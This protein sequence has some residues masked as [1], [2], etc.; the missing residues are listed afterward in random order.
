VQASQAAP[1]VGN[2]FVSVCCYQ[3]RYAVTL[4]IHLD[5]NM[6]MDARKQKNFTPYSTFLAGETTYLQLLEL[7]HGHVD[8]ECSR[9]IKPLIRIYSWYVF[10][11]SNSSS[12]MG[13]SGGGGSC[14]SILREG[15]SVGQGSRAR[16]PNQ[17]FMALLSNFR[18][19]SAAATASYV[20]GSSTHQESSKVYVDLRF[21][22]RL[23]ISMGCLWQVYRVLA[24]LTYKIAC[25]SD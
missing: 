7:I 25:L 15:K 19:S 16:A 1:S 9:L 21:L 20:D 2:I 23:R 17:F 3:R 12:V 24:F 5:K 6:M 4:T 11:S 22:H 8:G 13:M 18:T 14:M 10:I